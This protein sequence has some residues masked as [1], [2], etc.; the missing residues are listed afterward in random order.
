MS[1]DSSATSIL[2]VR[3]LVALADEV[4]VDLR[5]VLQAH[6]VNALLEDDA[7][8]VSDAVE[9]ALWEMLCR[10]G[11]VPDLGLRAAERLARG[12]FRGLEFCV[13]SSEDLGE[14]LA[15]VARFSRLLH[16]VGTFEFDHREAPTLRYTTE[17]PS[18]EQQVEFDVAVVTQLSRGTAHRSWVPTR[19]CFAH[20]AAGTEHE[21][22]AEAFFGC[23]VVFGVD[24]T[25]IELSAA[26]LELVMSEAEPVLSDVLEDA[27]EDQLAEAGNTLSL[28]A[29]VTAALRSQLTRGDPSLDGVSNALAM[30]RR[31][32][33]RGLTAEGTT[34][35]QLLESTRASLAR[36]YV[37]REGITLTGVATLLGY[38]DPTAFHRAFRRWVG[39]PPGEFR[40]T[41]APAKAAPGGSGP[42]TDS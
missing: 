4:G 21:R 34:F 2:I 32:I 39:V 35:S 6:G 12:S 27:L 41:S 14:A 18:L 16:G 1:A 17:K 36:S 10:A 30:S 40:R 31:S 19:V 22:L 25:C 20:I 9:T 37:A 24:A 5:G 29:H 26:D 33:Q 28:A 11:N 42:T 7:A 15:Q 23:P 3:A 38:S 8:T 13:R